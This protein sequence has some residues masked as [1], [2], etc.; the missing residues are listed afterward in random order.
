[1]EQKFRPRRNR[2]NQTIRDLIA[3]THLNIPQMVWPLFL[4]EGKNKIDPIKTLPDCYRFSLDAMIDVIRPY[5]NLGLRS[6]ALFPALS[7]ALK[8]QDAREA[9]NP[10]GLIPRAIKNLKDC[11]PDSIII[12][13]VALDPY[14]SEGHDGLL[15]NGKI[16][17]DATVEILANQALVQA[18]AG[19]DYVAPSDMMDGRVGF[20]RKAL[21]QEGFTDT[22][23]ISYAAKYASSFYGPFRE[24]LNSAPKYGDKKTYQMDFRNS[25]EALREIELD[26][27]EGADIL[28]IKPALSYLD[29][30]FQTKMNFH[31]PVAAYNVSG[32]YAMIKAAAQLGMMDEQSAMIETLTAIRRAGADLIFT[33]FA[34]SFVDYINKI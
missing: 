25:S 5:Y 21:D 24:A 29:V 8:T 17:N 27:Q 7:E 18:K 33:Y 9:Y 6:Y 31:L 32:E 2:R 30:I 10:D 23:I 11:F 12:T 19:S 1:M 4:Q 26:V 15:Q 14:S 28:L 34:P 16:N 3:E 20:I 22:G 13:D